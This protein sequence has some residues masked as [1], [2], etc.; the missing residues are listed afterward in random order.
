LYFILSIYEEGLK[1]EPG[2]SD[3]ATARDNAQLALRHPELMP[4]VV[5]P[6]SDRNSLLHLK[7]AGE[8]V[9]HNLRVLRE[10]TFAKDVTYMTQRLPGTLRCI[11]YVLVDSAARITSTNGMYIHQIN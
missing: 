7:Q 5:G 9:R 10:Q 3:I 11:Q 2:N 1:V 4:K 8:A 6:K